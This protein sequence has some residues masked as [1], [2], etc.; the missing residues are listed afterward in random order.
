MGARTALPARSWFRMKFARTGLSALP[1]RR[2][3]NPPWRA[4]LCESLLAIQQTPGFSGF[5]SGRLLRGGV[6]LQP[7]EVHVVRS[8]DEFLEGLFQRRFGARIEPPVNFNVPVGE[9]HSAGAVVVAGRKIDELSPSTRH[10]VDREIPVIYAVGP[11]INKNHGVGRRGRDNVAGLGVNAIIAIPSGRVRSHPAA[12]GD[13][14]NARVEPSKDTSNTSIR[15]ASVN[16]RRSGVGAELRI[17]RVQQ[18]NNIGVVRIVRLLVLR[19][20]PAGQPVARVNN[21]VRLF[22]P[23]VAG[24]DLLVVP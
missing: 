13:A 24:K 7:Q 1:S 17:A 19:G 9:G 12:H 15:Q 6:L 8:N 18:Q 10:H 23:I 3:L 20:Q 2:F 4:R 16:L 22:L 14:P 21:V 5:S 11:L